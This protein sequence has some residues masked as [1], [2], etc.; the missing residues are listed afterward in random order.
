MTHSD[1]VLDLVNSKLGGLVRRVIVEHGDTIAF[2]HP[3]KLNEI[4]SLL[5]LDAEL[6]FDML[7]YITAV[8]YLDSADQRFELVYQFLSIR[9]GHRLRLKVGVAEE[10]PSVPTATA[11]WHSAN[12]LERE[13]WDMYGIAFDGHPD[14]R[15]ILMYKEFDGHPLRKDYPVQ[16]KQPRVRLRRPEVR[17][18]AMDMVRPELVQIGG[19]SKKDL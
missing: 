14:L 16:G 5:K 19:T 15:R 17:N 4:F 3:D 2:A 10:A 1:S 7:V 9:N 12:V 8:D 11:W 6:H 13:V 18:T